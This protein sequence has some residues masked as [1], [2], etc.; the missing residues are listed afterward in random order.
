MIKSSD[1]RVGDIIT[2]Q[3]YFDEFPQTKM[4]V[5]VSSNTT[6]VKDDN[7]QTTVR[8]QNDQRASTDV[9]DTIIVY[10]EILQVYTREQNP[11]YFL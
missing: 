7:Y 6:T 3:N 4:V 10:G 2:Y 9:G 11:E 8:V 1:V 5:F